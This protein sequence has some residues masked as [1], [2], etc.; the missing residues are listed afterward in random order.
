MYG[1]APEQFLASLEQLLQRVHQEGLPA[2]TRQEIEIA[3]FDEAARMVR[4]VDVVA[5]PSFG[6]SGGRS[7]RSEACVSPSKESRRRSRQRGGGSRRLRRSVFSAPVRPAPADRATCRI[8]KRRFRHSL[9]A[10]WS[11]ASATTLA[12]NFFTRRGAAYCR[13]GGVRAA[14]VSKTADSAR[15]TRRLPQSNR[16]RK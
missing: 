1:E 15:R 11:S 9:H 13:S 8:R 2:R 16:G 4:L 6:F 3:P 12:A 5:V 7:C 14:W 10:S